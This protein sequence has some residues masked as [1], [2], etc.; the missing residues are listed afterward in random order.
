MKNIVIKG[1]E[2]GDL[3]KYSMKQLGCIEGGK[4]SGRINAENGILVKAGRISATKQWKEN[5][6]SELIKSSNGG[7]T[8]VKQ[9]KGCHSLSK[10]QLSKAGKLGY[11]NGLGKLSIKQKIKIASNAGLVNREKNA[12][13]KVKD[14]IFMRKYFIP[15]H[16]QFG[17][18]A[19]S[20]KYGVA[21]GTIRSAIKR[22]SFKD[23]K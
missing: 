16:P 9:K 11:S 18:V 1:L 12:T 4:T 8:A 23:I 19:F 17:V 3:S 14:V 10:K 20:K 13:L 7:K 22:K 2:D 15:R 5:R 21:E 6:E